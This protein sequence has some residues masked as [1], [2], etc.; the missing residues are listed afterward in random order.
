[1][2]RGTSAIST[3]EMLGCSAEFCGTNLMDATAG[4]HENVVGL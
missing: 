3:L 2:G 4:V 1:M